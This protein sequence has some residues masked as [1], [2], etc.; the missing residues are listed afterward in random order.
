MTRTAKSLV[1]IAALSAAL[2]AA[3]VSASTA[4]DMAF[5]IPAV[6]APQISVETLDS[7]MK[8][9]SMYSAMLVVS[10]PTYN[11]TILLEAAM[12]PMPTVL[13]ISRP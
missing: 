2:T 7:R 11:I 12:K 5:A 13:K 6:A 8:P 1:S 10:R 4:K 3:A 9:A